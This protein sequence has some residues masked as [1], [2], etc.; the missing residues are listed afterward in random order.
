MYRALAYHAHPCVSGSLDLHQGL[1]HV[2]LSVVPLHLLHLH[3]VPG[4][5]CSVQGAAC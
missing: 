5:A 2:V 1:H 3:H 4:H